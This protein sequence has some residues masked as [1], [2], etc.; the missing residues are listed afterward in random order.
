[1]LGGC[2]PLPLKDPHP[3][4]QP[5]EPKPVINYAPIKSIKQNKAVYI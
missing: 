3:T 1:M 4:T 2:E 5:T